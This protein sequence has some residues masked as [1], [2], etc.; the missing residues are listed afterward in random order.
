MLIAAQA[1]Q[2][3][4]LDLA[5]TVEAMAWL[6]VALFDSFLN[7]WTWKYRYNLVRPITYIRR[8]VDP[9]WSTFVNTPQFPEHTSGHSVSSRAA[10]GV[11][12]AVLGPM[13]FIDNSHAPRA[14]PAR[15]FSSFAAAADEAAQSRLY[16]GIHYPT[17]I[18]AGKACGDEIAAVLLRRLRTRR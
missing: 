15:S 11:L 17:G 10:A 1:A 18:E 4:R 7:C 6:G 13:P 3:Q 2:Q 14:M 12:T 5:R 16:G 9:T 8:Y